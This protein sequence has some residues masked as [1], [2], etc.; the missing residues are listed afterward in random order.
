MQGTLI[1]MTVRVAL[2]WLLARRMGLSAVA[3]ATGLGWCAVVSFQLIMYLLT[4]RGRE[5]PGERT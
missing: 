2:S 1:Q 3:L 5:V 4:V